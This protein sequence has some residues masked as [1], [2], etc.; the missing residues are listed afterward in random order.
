MLGVGPMSGD[1]SYVRELPHVWELSHVW[2]TCHIGELPHVRGAVP[3]RGTACIWVPV[4]AL[5]FPG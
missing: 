1:L 3:C 2:G 5:S 4:P